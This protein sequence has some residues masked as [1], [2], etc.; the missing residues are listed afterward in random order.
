LQFEISLLGD[1]GISMIAALAC[2][3]AASAGDAFAARLRRDH[4][5]AAR[6]MAL[7][8]DASL[9]EVI[10]ALHDPWTRRLD[11]R[12]AAD[13]LAEVRGEAH[14][15]IGLGR[16]A[17][18]SVDEP[19]RLAKQ[20]AQATPRNAA[21]QLERDPA[22]LTQVGR[23]VEAGIGLDQRVLLAW[24][25]LQRDAPIAAI[26]F[27]DRESLAPRLPGRMPERSGFDGA[28]QLEADRAHALQGH[29]WHVVGRAHEITKAT[30]GQRVKPACLVE[31]RTTNMIRRSP[32]RRAPRAGSR[33]RK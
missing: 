1:R 6:T 32:G 18:P 12:D 29:A 22:M 31:G 20:P 13:F 14:A 27:E 3:A 25:G 17:K 7:P 15:G 5:D 8:A 26:L 21:L 9:D 23:A 24:I 10:A 28:R 2:L 33:G 11:A 19:M 30:G 16:P 4:V